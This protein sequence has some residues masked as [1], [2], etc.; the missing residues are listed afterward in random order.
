MNKLYFFTTLLILAIFPQ[1]EA[2]GQTITVTSPNGGESWQPG[3]FHF[4]TFTD[5]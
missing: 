4:I 2:F 5:D 3:S 1:I